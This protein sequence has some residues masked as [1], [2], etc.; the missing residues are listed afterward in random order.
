VL[1]IAVVLVY[2]GAAMFNAGNGY[3]AAAGNAISVT[4]VLAKSAGSIGSKGIVMWE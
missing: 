2:V 3:R 4:S 1:A